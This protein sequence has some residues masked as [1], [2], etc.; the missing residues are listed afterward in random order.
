MRDYVYFPWVSAAPGCFLLSRWSLTAGSWRRRFTLSLT[1]VERTGAL[2]LL[3]AVPF[4][5]ITSSN[6]SLS[7]ELFPVIG[8]NRRVAVLVDSM[9]F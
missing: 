1:N 5:A 6:A 8:R 9:Y 4:G 3:C 2:T 7:V